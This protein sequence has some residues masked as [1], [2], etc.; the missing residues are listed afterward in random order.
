V[1]RAGEHGGDQ[2]ALVR[3]RDAGLDGD[4]EEAHASS[5]T[6]T[7][8]RRR[9]LDWGENLLVLSDW[10]EN[11]LLLLQALG[12]SAGDGRRDCDDRIG[13]D[14]Y[15]RKGDGGGTGGMLSVSLADA[16]ADAALDDAPE[17]DAARERRNRLR[18]DCCLGRRRTWP[19][20]AVRS[21]LLTSKGEVRDPRRRQQ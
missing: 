10:E 21:L 17:V 5:V 18:P 6:S 1:R 15:C 13:K 12:S 7:G 9:V 8:G 3:R 14:V 4:R 11:L 16:G 2:R 19:I 20:Q